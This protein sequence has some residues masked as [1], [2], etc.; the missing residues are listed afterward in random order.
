MQKAHFKTTNMARLEAAIKAYAPLCRLG[1][2]RAE[3]LKKM[4][5]MLLHP[6]PRVCSVTPSGHGLLY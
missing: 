3:V 6:F 4:V 1:H 5:S 2:L